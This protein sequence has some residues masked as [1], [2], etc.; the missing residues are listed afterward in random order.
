[1]KYIL[2]FENYKGKDKDVPFRDNKLLFDML[3]QTVD[4]RIYEFIINNYKKGFRKSP[5]G[6]SFYSGEVGWNYKE[7]NSYRVSDHWNF[8]TRKD[9]KIHCQT[10]SPVSDN[11]HWSIGIFREELGK[12]EILYSYPKVSNKNRYKNREKMREIRDE[13]FD[14]SSGI[15]KKC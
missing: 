4:Y 1:M 5:H 8:T 6:D 7:S 15:N 2:L 14:H 3:P 12:Y 13:F 9:N 10:I 11:S